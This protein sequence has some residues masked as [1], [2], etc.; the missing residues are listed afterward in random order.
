MDFYTEELLT[1]GQT[2]ESMALLRKLKS[3]LTDGEAESDRELNRYQYL[4]CGS[5]FQSLHGASKTSYPACASSR[6]RSASR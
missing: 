6:I 3:T 2:V 4:N 5:T 1:A